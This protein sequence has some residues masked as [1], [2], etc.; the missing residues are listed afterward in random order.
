[1]LADIKKMI[2]LK[3]EYLKNVLN[4]FEWFLYSLS[5]ASLIIFTYKVY[6][7]QKLTSSFKK[8]SI[9]SYVRFEHIQYWNDNLN[10]LFGFSSF[11][12]FIKMNKLLE[13]SK[14]IFILIASVNKSMNRMVFFIFVILIAYLSF[15]QIFFI[16]LNQRMFAFSTFIGT[17]E[18]L[19]EVTLGKFQAKAFW[20][21]SPWIGIASFILF[22]SVV[23][24]CL[25]NIFFTIVGE[26]FNE[27]KQS[28]YTENLDIMEGFLSVFKTAKKTKKR[29]HKI[30]DPDYYSQ[31]KEIQSKV[32]SLSK[33]LENLKI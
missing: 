15:A 29:I 21:A 13:K 10:M 26:S 30:E 14:T 23:V 2:K 22:N 12:G 20:D 31:E 16:I 25:L 11:V 1:M 9:K 27:T 5:L 17:L 8:N 24:I 6:A 7:A 18:T 28:I 32:K 3:I 19:F 33:K 4:I